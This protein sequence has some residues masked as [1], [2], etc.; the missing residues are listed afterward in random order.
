MIASAI[1]VQRLMILHDELDDRA[2]IVLHMCT[3]MQSS[4]VCLPGI[5]VNI[6][7]QT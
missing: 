1:G 2:M 7:G 5:Q 6:E 3:H 4:H